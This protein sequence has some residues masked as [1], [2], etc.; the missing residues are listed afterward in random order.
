MII[1]LCLIQEPAIV[2]DQAIVNQLVDMGFGLE[3]CKK[4]VFHTKNAGAE[5]A[6]NWVMEHMGDADFN[7]PFVQ[8]G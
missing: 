4:A 3:G 6:M 5:A 1:H 2:P 8:P 7:D